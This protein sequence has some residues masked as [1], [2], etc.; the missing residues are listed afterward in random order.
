[1][2]VMQSVGFSQSAGRVKRTSADRAGLAQALAA[3][4][5]GVAIT[6]V[7]AS[8]RGKSKVALARQ[9]AMYLCHAVFRL[10]A[11]ELAE[12]FGRD[13]STTRYALRQITDMRNDAEFDRT[14]IYL[15]SMLR[16]A[17]GDAA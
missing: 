2:V 10:D 14:I 13:D 7:R 4:V 6:D 17:A 9:V 8:T 5:Y 15:E 11:K 12:T 1:V 16:Q 3:Y